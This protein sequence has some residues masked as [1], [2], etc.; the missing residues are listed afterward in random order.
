MLG[1]WHHGRLCRRHFVC[2]VPAPLPQAQKEDGD[3]PPQSERR[4]YPERPGNSAYRMGRVR[5]GERRNRWLS[6]QIRHQPVGRGRREVS[7][8]GRAQNPFHWRGTVTDPQAFVGRDRDMS[9]IFARLRQLG[10]VSVVGE[11]RIGKSSLAYQASRR[12]AEQL[13]PDSCAV[14]ID[15]LSAG[16]HTLE[17]L[18]PAILKGLGAEPTPA[19]GG[20]SAARLAAFETDIRA[21]RKQGALPVVFL[22]EFEALGSRV[23]QFGDDLL[24]S[25]RSLGNDNQMAFVTTSARPLD[26]VTQES[27]FTSSFYNIFAQTKLEE[28]TEREAKAF[29]QMAARV[30]KFEVGDDVF[31]LRV[32]G[33]HPLRLQIAAWHLFEARQA[34]KVDFGL[35]E[36]QAKA[37]IA[38]MMA[39]K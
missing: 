33:L 26:E 28:F 32:G 11:R 12:A 10:C 36:Q 23:E 30:A 29:V 17:G 31:I 22:D 38:G 25:W 9:G 5:S 8:M 7:G 35:L 20:S 19:T 14:Y 18:L 1:L 34:G 39:E 37:E 21:L 13:G 16:H 15:M 2:S 27:G 6:E 24:E 4:P 3:A